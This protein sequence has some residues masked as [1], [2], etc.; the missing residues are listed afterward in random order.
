[1]G[2][3]GGG[4]VSDIVASDYMQELAPWPEDNSSLL[5]NFSLK[6]NNIVE[7]KDKQL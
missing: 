2:S 6:I 3:D 1:M 5:V 7:S 4:G